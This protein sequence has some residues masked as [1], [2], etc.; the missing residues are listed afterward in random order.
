MEIKYKDII[1]RDYQET[2]IAD[3]IRWMTVE[4]AWQDWDA[5]WEK[6][7]EFDA[8]K[9]RTKMLKRLETKP[10]DSDFRWAFE[11]DTKDGVHIGGV[12]S[13]LIDAEY[14]W[15][16]GRKGKGLYTLGI[17]ICESSYWYRGYGTQAFSA[18][19]LYMNSQGI[20]DLFTQTWSGNLPMLA[21]AKRLGFDE[22]N[23]VKN[24]RVVRGRRYAALTFKLNMKKFNG[25][26]EK[27]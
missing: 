5:P 3:D 23:R 26:S 15:I 12:N 19:I 17:D 6:D 25:F 10:E 7:E 1:L 20:T 18:F 24:Y 2:D 22:V 21:L 13:Y 14:N 9:F 8:D 4:T 11:I 16:P 27:G